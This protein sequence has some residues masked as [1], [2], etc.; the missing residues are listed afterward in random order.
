MVKPESLFQNAL[1][2]PSKNETVDLEEDLDIDQEIE[3]SK[4]DKKFL[5]DNHYMVV[6][7]DPGFRELLKLAHLDRVLYFA[8]S[9]F[10]RRETMVPQGSGKINHQ[11][12]ERDERRIPTQALAR[13]QTISRFPSQVQCLSTSWE[14][15]IHPALSP[16]AATPSSSPSATCLHPSPAAK[17]VKAHLLLRELSRPDHQQPQ[18]LLIQLFQDSGQS[19]DQD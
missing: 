15:W 19:A 11:A 6:Q 14:L 1:G 17:S 9:K 10:Q 5:E 13:I 12:T 8:N 4:P 7:E 3:E 16:T 18:C 2:S